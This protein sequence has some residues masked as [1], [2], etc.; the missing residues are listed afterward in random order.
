MLDLAQCI[1]IDR[2][3]IGRDLHYR[4]LH[5]LP[6]DCTDLRIQVEKDDDFIAHIAAHEYKEAMARI[7]ALNGNGSLRDELLNEEIF[8]SLDDARRKLALWRYDYNTIRP[9]SS[10]ANQTPQQARRTLE[11]FEGFAP[12]ALAPDD[13]A[14]YRNPNCRLSS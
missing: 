9:H 2:A 14:E 12:G 1:G 8:D 5:Y 6:P 10:L 7:L 4:I 13:Q 3:H 11:Q